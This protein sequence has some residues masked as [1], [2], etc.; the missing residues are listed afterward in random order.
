MR[1]SIR[2]SPPSEGKLYGWHREGK[3]GIVR[4]T[5]GRITFHQLQY[6]LVSSWKRRRHDLIENEVA[7]EGKKY[8][9]CIGKRVSLSHQSQVHRPAKVGDNTF[10]G[11]QALVF[12]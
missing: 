8:S 5:R 2:R 6:V 12:S 9:V 1:L 7:V 4:S 10:V 11:M 3:P